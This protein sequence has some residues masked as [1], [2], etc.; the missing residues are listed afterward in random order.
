[1]GNFYPLFYLNR[2]VISAFFIGWQN[3]FWDM[4]IDSKIRAE[5]TLG[6]SDQNNYGLI[7]AMLES[8]LKSYDGHLLDVGCGRGHLWN[9]LQPLFKSCT[10]IDVVRHD[11][12]P[13]EREL[14]LQDLD[15]EP[16][17]L[18]DACA[19]VVVACEVTPCLENPRAL[20]RQMARLV[21]PGGWVVVTNPNCRSLTSL[22][23][24]VLFGEWRLFR[25][26]GYP[27]MISPILEVDMRR[28]VQE[29]ELTELSFFY[30]GR[31]RLPFSNRYF[32]LVLG[33]WFPRCFSDHV[34]II[35][36]RKNL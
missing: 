28:M 17:A 1:M 22:M 14:V 6:I 10:G 13:A 33:K 21:K 19:D 18:P 15:H 11:E 34:G 29:V 7:R 12:S 5:K 4:K 24:L 35:A 8:R 16:Y 9:V 32:P 31:A 30:S 2:K 3:N 23:T 27:F 36:R 26:S 25:D 20:F